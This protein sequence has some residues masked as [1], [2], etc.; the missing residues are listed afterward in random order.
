LGECIASD[1]LTSSFVA[2][3]NGDRFVDDPGTRLAE[4]DCVLIFSADA[5]G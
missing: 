1:R 4:E 3:L 5:G 2:N